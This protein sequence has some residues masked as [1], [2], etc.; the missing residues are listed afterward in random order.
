MTA[1]RHFIFGLIFVPATCLTGNE[2]SVPVGATTSDFSVSSNAIATPPDEE[3][4]ASERYDEM[5]GRMQNA[6]EE[7]AQQYGNPL[8]LQVFTNDPERAAELKARLISDRRAEDIRRELVS[9]ER[10]RADLLS[11]LAFKEQQTKKLEEKLVRQRT[12][13]DALATAIE[14]ARRAVEDTSR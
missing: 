12:A 11:D 2:Q 13:L 4:R 6:L 9:L 1:M 8:F 5:L 14:Q 3:S 10:R 7:I